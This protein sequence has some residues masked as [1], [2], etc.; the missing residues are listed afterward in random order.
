MKPTNNTNGRFTVNDTDVETLTFSE[1]LDGVLDIL[2]SNG[3]VITAQYLYGG[4]LQPS[5]RFSNTT[6]LFTHHAQVRDEAWPLSLTREG[7]LL[8]Y[9]DE[10]GVALATPQRDWEIVVSFPTVYVESCKIREAR[11]TVS[12]LGHVFTSP[13]S[14]FGEEETSPGL[15][16][17][18][19]L[20]SRDSPC[21]RTLRV[22]FQ[23]G[24][25]YLGVLIGD[26]VRWFSVGNMVG[27]E[28]QSGAGILDLV[29]LPDSI[30]MVTSRGVVTVRES[31]TSTTPYTLQHAS[32]T[33]YIQCPSVT[34][35]T[36]TI[37]LNKTTVVT[38]R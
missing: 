30:V 21:S 16:A 36:V 17:E 22:V 10:G 12:F 7:L 1:D 35:D 14:Y 5:V 4:I 8:R 19:E 18:E 9:H 34:N 13:S 32:I 24:S 2:N 37:T 3:D 23:K 31:N 20:Q 6:T 25:P 38:G 11:L 27:E 26:I 28:E 33:S 15:L 29:L